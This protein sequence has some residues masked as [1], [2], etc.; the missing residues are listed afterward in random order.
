[1]L[2][3]VLCVFYNSFILH[4][5]FKYLILHAHIKILILFIVESFFLLQPLTN[6]KIEN[7]KP[8]GSVNEVG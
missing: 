1:M 4:A 5:H 7:M 2:A 6:S 3:V 8:C